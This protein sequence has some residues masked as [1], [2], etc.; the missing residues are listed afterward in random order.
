VSAAALTEAAIGIGFLL[1][2]VGVTIA[3]SVRSGAH[4][5]KRVGEIVKLI[6]GARSAGAR[7][8][9]ARLLLSVPI[10]FDLQPTVVAWVSRLLRDG[11]G[12]PSQLAT[13]ST[14]VARLRFSAPDLA[15]LYQQS[16]D[17]VE[18]SS[19][20][21]AAKELA[22]RLGRLSYA[23]GRPDRRPTIYDEQAVAN[24]IA[25]RA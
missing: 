23:A 22:L 4:E 17:V 20:T 21:P 8:D 15:L 3:L 16:L 5:R 18:S 19:G 14:I 7:D 25:M 6:N 11:V 24:D 2:V 13:A 10:P 12:D 1:V 9:L